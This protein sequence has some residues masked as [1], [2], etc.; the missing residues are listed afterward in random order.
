[1][2]EIK[3][4]KLYRWCFKCFPFVILFSLKFWYFSI[5][6]NNKCIWFVNCQQFI[7]WSITGNRLHLTFAKYHFTRV[8]E[9]QSGCC[10]CSSV[11]YQALLLSSFFFV[12]PQLVSLILFPNFS[13]LLWSWSGRKLESSCVCNEWKNWKFWRIF[14]RNYLNN[15]FVNTL[16]NTGIYMFI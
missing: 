16:L 10:C 9:R 14:R 1:M 11:M 7:V 6:L 12:V 5:I 13:A 15:L 2:R 8:C 4:F 3:I